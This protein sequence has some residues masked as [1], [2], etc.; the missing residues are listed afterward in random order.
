M[1][2]SIGI[3]TP[4]LSQLFNFQP[5]V[6]TGQR[7]TPLV[8]P[9]NTA[10]TITFQHLRVND[11][12]L[13]VPPYPQGYT[14]TV[15]PGN[16][17]NLV[18]ATVTP[19]NNF[20]G[21]LTVQVQVNDGKFDS[22]I[23]DLKIDVV[24]ST[25]VITDHEAI[26][27]KEGNSFTLLLKHLKVDDDD[28]VFPDDFTLTI[29]D[30]PS[31]TISGTTIT[32]DAGFSG[33]LKVLVS[34]NDGYAESDKFEVKIDVNA[35]IV[36]VIKN[37]TSLFTDQ[38]K[39]ITLT[40]ENLVVEDP[41]NAYPTGFSLK[42][43][44][45]SNYTVNGHTITPNIT[46]VGTLKVPVTVHD[47]LDESKKFELNID[48][49]PKN[50]IAPR[51]VSHDALS[52]KED[53]SIIVTLDNLNVIDE[54]NNYPD[55]FV[56]KIPQG[57]G[58]N[59]TVSGNKITPALNFNGALAVPVRVNDAL[60]DSEPFL[61][62]ISVTPVNDVPVITGQSEII[63]RSNRSTLLDVT[64]LEISDA[65]T[66]N[67]SNFKLKILPGTNY[68]ASG[69]ELT[70]NTDFIGKLTVSV[71]VNDGVVDSAPYN[72]IVEVVPGGSAPLI[73]GQQP[74]VMNEDESIKLKLEDLVVTDDDDTYPIGFT[75]KVLPG[76][77]AADYSFQGL[78]VT[79]RLNTNG[80]LT[81]LVTVNDGSEA[82]DPFELNIYVVPV[83]DAPQV[84]NL[85]EVSIPYEPGTGPVAITEHL[86]VEDI[87]NAYLSY[88]EI[89]IGD[90]TF[91]VAN[92]ELIY[93]NTEEIRGIYDPTKGI[94]SLI[95]TASAD[96]Y[97]E[98][99]RSI[100]YNYILTIDDDGSQSEVLPGEKKIIFTI[101][102]G[103]LTSDRQK[104]T[105]IIE[106]SVELDI[107]N[108]FTPNGDEANDTWRVRPV[109]NA[110][111]FDKAVVKVF[112]K[113]G[114][115]IYESKGFE[116]GWDGSFNGERLPVD[117]YYYTIDLKLSYTK[118]TYKG[119]VTILR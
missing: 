27:I 9:R 59:Y 29:Y 69:N 88:A 42:I 52:I 65:D 14:L 100:K 6:I 45:G 114:L 109:A 43:Y 70:P 7:P 98:A 37:Q 41:D 110:N 22:N 8:T 89:S 119:T 63:I 56:L 51:I 10:V 112:N 23:Y 77:P 76:D 35:N 54:D 99:I 96:A 86:T 31:Y 18:N 40:F 13:L 71:V 84:K 4:A 68:T 39:K 5:P 12:D 92:D 75:M 93:E 25:P 60:A 33:E 57:N 104:R 78:S 61:I 44:N 83:N 49:L 117:T 15:F 46:F 95:G 3:T 62:S 103:Q 97:Y 26:S 73:T 17:Y 94:L 16:N 108:A 30:G 21:T 67:T 85:E 74:L 66:E 91:N 72:L 53:Q 79:P 34:V 1:I 55:D 19:D 11:P 107:P 20:M 50:N 87:D 113:K 82:S 105:I 47:G 118:K 64:R 58:K 2:L 111:Q 32:P 90:S 48:V 115:L 24:N 106:S 36:P 102:D 28:N 80:L 38:G 81:V 116:K 101:S